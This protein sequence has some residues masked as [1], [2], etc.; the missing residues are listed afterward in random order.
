VFPGQWDPWDIGGNSCGSESI[1]S[2]DFLPTPSI[3]ECSDTVCKISEEP[4]GDTLF[5][6]VGVSPVD[7]SADLYRLCELLGLNKD[8]L[9]CNHEFRSHNPVKHDI[10]RVVENGFSESASH[11]DLWIRQLF[12]EETNPFCCALLLIAKSSSCKGR[13]LTLN[14]ALKFPSM[15]HEWLCQKQASERI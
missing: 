14:G 8:A 7:P 9:S 10:D 13:N 4:L 11:L 3:N 6:D 1:L 5:A 2:L 12:K 15:V